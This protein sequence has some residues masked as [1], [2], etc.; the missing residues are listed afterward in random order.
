MDNTHKNKKH[1]LII[2]VKNPILGHVKSRLALK[3]G[4]ANALEIYNE[5]VDKIHK[6]VRELNCDKQVAYSSSIETNDIWE[7]DRFDKILQQGTDIGTRM[8]DAF[9]SAFQKGYENVVLIG[10]D[11]IGLQSGIIHQAFKH[12]EKADVVL[13]PAKDGG[14]YLVGMKQPRKKIFEN[15]DWGTSKV[16]IQT[17]KTCLDLDVSVQLVTELAD[18]DRIEDFQYLDLDEWKKYIRLIEKDASK[19]THPSLYH[20]LRLGA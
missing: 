6:I 10:S 7:N 19:M 11:I 20:F 4:Y 2:F 8:Y 16:F 18:L 13:G 9:N 17:L 12:L 3:I 1:L 15:K 14:Y 5:L